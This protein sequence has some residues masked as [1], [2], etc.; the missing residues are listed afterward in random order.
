MKRSNKKH[1]S[2]RFL[3]LAIF[4]TITTLLWV[5]FEIFR[6]LTTPADVT[7]VSQEEL[8]PLQGIINSERLRSIR[9]RVHI[10][11]QEL[12]SLEVSPPEFSPDQS[13]NEST[14]GA[15]INQNQEAT[16]SGGF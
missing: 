3:Y 1:F 2:M 6:S 9:N 8:M 4:T 14:G 12:D 16:S 15:T 7:Q 13:V 10:P 11:Q 5:G